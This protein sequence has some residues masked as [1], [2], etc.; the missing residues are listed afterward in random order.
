MI[1]LAFMVSGIRERDMFTNRKLENKIGMLAVPL[2]NASFEPWK[3]LVL[4]PLCAAGRLE[5]KV[6]SL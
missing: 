3:V 5:A 6:G 1:L 2:L 4:I